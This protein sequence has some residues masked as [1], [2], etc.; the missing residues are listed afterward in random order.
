[1]DGI[2]LYDSFSRLPGTETYREPG[3]NSLYNSSFVDKNGLGG[4]QLITVIQDSSNNSTPENQNSRFC[5]MKS[6]GSV[7]GFQTEWRY[8]PAY[9]SPEFCVT[10][11][12]VKSNWNYARQLAILV[13]GIPGM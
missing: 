10:I 11:P 1:M 2:T 12:L 13:Y 5:F 6:G 7:S 9:Q 4:R 3:V 8:A